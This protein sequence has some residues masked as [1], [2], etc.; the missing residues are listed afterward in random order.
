ML[1]FH[2]LGSPK[3]LIGAQT[4]EVRPS[5][6]AALLFYLVIQGSWVSRDAL[7]ELLLPEAGE[8]Q[9]RHNLRLNLSRALK[10]PWARG[11]EVESS[12]LRFAARTDVAEVERAAEEREFEQVISLY[13]SPLLSGFP[14]IHLPALAAWAEEERARIEQ[15]FLEALSGRADQLRSAGRSREALDCLEQRLVRE[16]LSERT[17]QA[18][19]SLCL[20]LEDRERGVRLYARFAQELLTETQLEPLPPTW[21]LVEALRRGSKAL[22]RAAPLP[23]SLQSS[24]HLVGRAAE[25]ARLRS[26]LPGWV[27]LSGEAGVGK[28]HLLRDA[29]PQAR[30]LSGVEGLSGVPYHP[31]IAHLRREPLPDVGAYTQDLARVLPELS[32]HLPP[33]LDPHT[34]RLR[35]LEALARALTADSRPIV[36]DDAQWADDATLEWLSYVRERP[37]LSVVIAYRRE[38]Q[39]TLSRWLGPWRSGALELPLEPLSQDDLGEWLR[40]LIDRPDVP[41]HFAAWLH[42]HSGGHPLYALETLRSLFEAGVLRFGQHDWHT[43]LDQRTKDYAELP[44]PPKL[45]QLVQARLE[46]LPLPVQRLLEA[47]SVLGDV[48]AAAQRPLLGTLLHLSEL[49]VLDGVEAAQAAALLRQDQ[50][51]A[52]EDLGLSFAHDLL[53]QAISAA[54]SPAR[55]RYLHA[56]AAAW[57]E[58]RPAQWQMENLSAVIARHWEQAGQPENS[59]PA[60]VRWAEELQSRGQYAAASELWRGLLA[61]FPAAHPLECQTRVLLGR[62]LLWENLDEGSQQLLTALDLLSQDGDGAEE[63]GEHQAALLKLEAQIGLSELALYWGDVP[64]ARQ[65]LAAATEQVERLETAGQR[66]P[67]PLAQSLT[68]QR[69]ETGFRGGAFSEVQRLLAAEAAPWPMLRVYQAH[70]DFYA[71]RYRRAAQTLAA[72]LK[73]FPELAHVQTL[74]A[75]LG[76]CHVFLGDLAAGRAALTASLERTSNLHALTLGHSNMGLLELYAGRLPEAQQHLA[77]AAALAR[78]INS[79]TYLAD[80]L[81]RQAGI[82]FVSGDWGAVFAL[83]HEA[84]ALM[85]AVGDPFRQMYVGCVYAALLAF[86]GR[87]AQARALLSAYSLSADTPLMARMFYHR[88]YAALYLVSGRAHL[89]GPHSRAD[90]GL[91]R[92][93]EFQYELEHAQRLSDQIAAALTHRP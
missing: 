38:E 76:L 5:K 44:P 73:R 29:L 69:I 20:S 66:L 26:A 60:K 3:V 70:L 62:L 9:A 48:G 6:P 86:Q 57:L 75:D 22:P 71:G 41:H 16:P 27:L 19:L 65:W 92:A 40:S 4:F 78:Q 24:A 43:D 64:Q 82:H 55:R 74:E 61:A 63:A 33:L 31:L 81:H 89:A 87:E 47:L 88:A 68:E 54:L 56:G 59:W 10:L 14:L 1:E 42:R 2:L 79:N 84:H 18:A 72:L 80:V 77:Q 17:L 25:R 8:Q 83:L 39:H 46:R 49:E 85:Q 12:R 51:A 32:S 45:R 7:A 53:R 58:Q 13:H 67:P 11:V 34:A 36:L 30:F 28:S 15:V 21:A 23:A 35:L 90:V 52:G 37:A 91:A 50:G 93:A